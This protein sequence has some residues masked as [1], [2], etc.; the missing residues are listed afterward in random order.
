[1]RVIGTA[2]H[3]DHG[4]SALVLALTGINPDRLREEQERQM[5]IDLGFAWLTLDDGEE[6]GIV[7]VPGHR[8]FIENMLAGVGAIDAVLFVIAADEGIMPQTREHLAILDLLRIPRG[9]IALTKSDLVDEEWIELVKDETHSLFQKTLLQNAPIVPVSSVSGEGLAEVKEALTQVLGGAPEAINI[10]RPRLP[11]DRVFTL[12]GFGTVVTGTLIGGAFQEGQDVEVQPKGIKARIRSLQAHKHKRKQVDPGGRVAINLSGVDKSDI[13]RGD[14]VV[15][16]NQWKPTKMIDANLRLLGGLDKPLKHNQE[17]KLFHGTEQR[18]A[19]VRLIGQPQIKSGESGWIQLILTEAIIA[20]RGDHYILRRPSPG[21]TL[22]GG[23]VVDPDP[24]QRYR[25]K[26]RSPIDRLE[27]LLAGDPQDIVLEV[28]RNH[29]PIQFRDVIHRADMNQESGLPVIQE[30]LARGV[31]I[32]LGKEVDPVKAFYVT[33]HAWEVARNKS[34][35]ILVSY[36]QQHPLRHG[37][38][39][40]EYR[41][42]MELDPKWSAQ[43]LKLA[44]TDGWL[45]QETNA[46]RYS[47][48]HPSLTKKQESAVSGLLQ[49]FHSQPFNTPSRRAILELIDEEVLQFLIGRGTLIALSDEVFLDKDTYSRAVDDIRERLVKQNTLTVAEVR[50]IFKTSRKYALA[51]MEHLDSIGVT[52]REEDVRRLKV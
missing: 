9:I 21:A 8:D 35:G 2:G 17:V 4:K 18:M 26:D 13:E 12:T 38:P 11:I 27:K 10:G 47:S 32:G 30:L 36:H 52:V 46:V 50:D 43:Y 3:V 7:D 19:K 41:K 48:H 45:L 22:G 34:E 39:V 40:E 42:R 16:R 44:E 28:I 33:E 29:G 6:V 49:T 14:V 25:L 37:M 1:M 51:L 20:D 23:Q 15:L 31:L 24:D 5:T